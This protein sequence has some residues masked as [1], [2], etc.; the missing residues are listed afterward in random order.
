MGRC[1]V[2]QSVCSA[3]WTQSHANLNKQWPN[4]PEPLTAYLISS[5]FSSKSKLGYKSGESILDGQIEMLEIQDK[6]R[7]FLKGKDVYM[8][9]T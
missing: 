9:A 4:M 3:G 6:N 2:F 5:H 1:C 8:S 7:L